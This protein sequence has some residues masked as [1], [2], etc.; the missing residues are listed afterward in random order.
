VTLQFGESLTYD[1]SSV[2]YNRNMFI[3]QATGVLIASLTLRL[4]ALGKLVDEIDS[5]GLYHKTLRIRNLRK[6][7]KFRSKLVSFD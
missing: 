4:C 5:R 3:I 6:M 7:D 2:N 1:T